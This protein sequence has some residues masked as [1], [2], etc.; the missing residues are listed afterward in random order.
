MQQRFGY[1]H[2]VQRSH[3]TMWPR[4]EIQVTFD[5][6]KQSQTQEQNRDAPCIHPASCT[7]SPAADCASSFLLVSST[8]AFGI[9]T[10]PRIWILAG[11]SV[12]Q[13]WIQQQIADLFIEIH[14][15][16]Q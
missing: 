16:D 5:I 6:P 1:D 13:C 9:S 15:K 4:A 3:G 10:A 2:H 8:A 7:L 12:L 11:S 14:L